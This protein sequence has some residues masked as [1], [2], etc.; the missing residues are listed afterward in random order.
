MQLMW[1]LVEMHRD[2][3]STC[4]LMLDNRME[5]D[6]SRLLLTSDRVRDNS[7]NTFRDLMQRLEVQAPFQRTFASSAFQGRNSRLVESSAQA[8]L[9][10]PQLS[11]VQTLHSLADLDTDDGTKKTEEQ[12]KLL[13]ERYIETLP[14]PNRSPGPPPTPPVEASDGYNAF[15]PGPV[16]E[17]WF[18]GSLS[19]WQCMKCGS[20]IS[21]DYNKVDRSQAFANLVFS[22]HLPVRSETVSYKCILCRETGVAAPEALQVF[23]KMELVA[24]LGTHS[25]R[26]FNRAGFDGA[27][28]RSSCLVP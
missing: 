18:A 6:P 25:V 12:L 8:H 24:H 21:F 1:N 22:C 9:P 7:V 26:D 11:R 17:R 14:D 13:A 28:L 19:L 10:S 15:C 27:I 23:E 5:Y 3:L 16:E 20:S 2:M 4:R